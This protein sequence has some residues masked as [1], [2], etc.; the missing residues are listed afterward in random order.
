MSDYELSTF[1]WK[2]MLGRPSGVI[3]AI[4]CASTPKFD[5]APLINPHGNH[6]NYPVSIPPRLQDRMA[7]KRVYRLSFVDCVL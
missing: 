3:S 7:A 1:I 5:N 6:R 4:T 2:D